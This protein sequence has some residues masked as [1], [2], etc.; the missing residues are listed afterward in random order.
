MVTIAPPTLR[1]IA[2]PTLVMGVPTATLPGIAAR[3]VA[4]TPAVVTIAAIPVTIAAAA[5]TILA[6]VA[7]I[8]RV[9][10]RSLPVS[11]NTASF[12]E[13]WMAIRGWPMERLIWGRM[14]LMA[15]QY[16]KPLSMWMPM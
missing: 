2:L 12:R 4:T 11:A 13:T 6:A 1:P 10:T 7:G 9:I 16:P 14:S 3:V 15:L 5:G 8:H